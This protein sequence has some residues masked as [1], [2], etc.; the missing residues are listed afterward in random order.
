LP[1]EASVERFDIF[2]SYARRD[3]AGYWLSRLVELIVADF[4][5]FTSRP[6]RIF[7]DRDAIRDMDDWRIRILEGLRS[8]RVLLVCVSP[9]YLAS[10]YCSWEWAEY[11]RR[12]AHLLGGGDSVA[13]VY[14]VELG[15]PSAGAVA[16]WRQ[17]V[18]RVQLTDVRQWFS[19]GTAA[20]EL[21]E[22][23]H[24]VGQLGMSLWDRISRAERAQ[25][26]PGNLRRFNPYSVGRSEE[27]R[28]VRAGLAAGSVGAVTVVHGVGGQGK[29]ELAVMYTHSFA[30]LYGGGA[31]VVQADRR[32]DL[33]AVIADLALV[34]ELRLELSSEELRHPAIAAR[35]VLAR[36]RDLAAAARDKT[37]TSG[38]C[39]LLLDNVTEPE[40]LSADQL[41]LLPAEPWLHLLATT[42]LGPPDLAGSRPDLAFVPLGELPEND[43]L[44]LLR[45]HQ[46]PRDADGL[47]PDFATEADEQ[48]GREIVREVGGF[49][50]AVE[51]IAVFL[52]LNPEL[53]PASFL[54]RLRELALTSLDT[55]PGVE[56]AIRHQDRALGTVLLDTINRLPGRARDALGIATFLPPDRIP[57]DWL[58]DM[59]R[60]EDEAAGPW[61]GLIDD[62]AVTRRLLEGRRLLVSADDLAVA[63]IHRIVA[64]HLRA[65]LATPELAARLDEHLADDIET[66]CTAD[67]VDPPALAYLAAATAKRMAE[68]HAVVRAAVYLLERLSGYVGSDVV[69]DLGTACVAASRALLEHEPDD[70]DCSADLARA[71]LVLS[72]ALWSRGEHAAALTCG[73][74]AVEIL[75][76]LMDRSEYELSRCHGF[77]SA[78]ESL[79]SLLDL[80]GEASRALA[81]Y[82]QALAVR[83]AVIDTHR[84]E[85]AVRRLARSL[86][87][88]AGVLSRSGEHQAALAHMGEA[89]QLFSDLLQDKPATPEDWADVAVL[90][91]A[92]GAA[93]RR[94][95]KL[96]EALAQYEPAAGILR[97]LIRAD[98]LDTGLTDSLAGVLSS[99]GGIQVDQGDLEA[100]LAS[101]QEEVSLRR[102][103]SE[104]DADDL[105]RALLLADA[106]SNVG[107]LLADRGDP[108]A[109]LRH[110]QEALP[111][112]SRAIG[113]DGYLMFGEG[114]ARWAVSVGNLHAERGEQAEASRY[115]GAAVAFLRAL[116]AQDPDGTLRHRYGEDSGAVADPGFW[117]DHLNAAVDAALPLWR[118]HGDADA[119]LERLGEIMT[120]C[121]ALADAH[122]G[123]PRW[124]ANTA[125]VLECEGT[126]LADRGDRQAA[127]AVFD[128]AGQ[129]YRALVEADPADT[130]WEERL[131]R[132]TERESRPQPP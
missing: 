73:L 81:V 19:A 57:W 23:R 33:L 117:I 123:D 119:A 36:L 68:N 77:A 128:E 25:V 13:G 54:A 113:A 84:D 66:A 99:I 8:S 39:V 122:P 118:E 97:F 21:D 115:Y 62:W 92:A 20:F 55:L 132:L 101:Y 59:T 12:R 87:M 83:R 35:K 71:L 91:Q 18:E 112:A 52:G 49:T 121:R 94:D 24:R 126:V 34:P 129:I 85:E 69:V 64:D 116:V 125:G 67:P 75:S 70:P 16:G 90:R 14:I 106:L 42:R 102:R 130:E 124:T 6:L 110:Y 88:V 82:Q 96:A 63:R 3:D 120:V 86:L 48:A 72:H 114:F 17:D 46:P 44:E 43:A 31:W 131:D 11:A 65:H 127:D 4:R 104:A 78:A 28:Q 89:G 109:G 10:D 15:G 7:F 58:R 107:W 45:E 98:P 79:A 22:V 1:N 111:I 103:G 95:D 47:R 61:A 50:L 76:R 37:E 2:V 80:N 105:D 38:A 40:L 29:T 100:A 108:A 27:L 41:A 30:H 56:E 5:H 53:S 74:E 26:A 32:T 93:F 9:S 51:Q 60:P